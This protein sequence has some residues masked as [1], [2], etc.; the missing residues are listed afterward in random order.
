M[1]QTSLKDANE[2]KAWKQN[3]ADFQNFWLLLVFKSTK[4]M[5]SSSCL[6]EIPLSGN[7]CLQLL[8][9]LH[10]QLFQPGSTVWLHM[11]TWQLIF[12]QDFRFRIEK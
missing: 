4:H 2:V 8:P 11:K 10:F 1:Q 9:T 7:S 3:S 12:K 5:E 6:C